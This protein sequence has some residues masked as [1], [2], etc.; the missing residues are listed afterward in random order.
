M[1]VESTRP[2]LHQPQVPRAWVTS[3]LPPQAARRQLL[4]VYTHKAGQL[5]PMCASGRVSFCVGQWDRRQTGPK[6][7]SVS[8][9][10]V[11]NSSACLPSTPADEQ[12]L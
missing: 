5:C 1:S 2:G 4:L 3:R 8:L 9:E 7:V 10:N 6:P 12:C 11:L